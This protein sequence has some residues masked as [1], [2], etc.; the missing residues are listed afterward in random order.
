MSCECPTAEI[1]S[2]TTLLEADWLSGKL[3]KT[4]AAGRFVDDPEPE[5]SMPIH[6]Q[7]CHELMPYAATDFYPHTSPVGRR[8]LDLRTCRDADGCRTRIKEKWPNLP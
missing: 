5:P 7:R 4:Q 2:A 3:N 6:C 8:V 1:C